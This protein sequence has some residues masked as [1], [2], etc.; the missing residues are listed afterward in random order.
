M[1]CPSEETLDS[2]EPYNL[3]FLFQNSSQI[4]PI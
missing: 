2:V 4:E 3:A 1:I